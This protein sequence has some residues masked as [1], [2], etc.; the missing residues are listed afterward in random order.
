MW[1]DEFLNPERIQEQLVC[2]PEGRQVTFEP[3]STSCNG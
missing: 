2:G 1:F 3:I